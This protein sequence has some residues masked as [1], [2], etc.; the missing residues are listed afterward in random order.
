[1][2]NRNQI[3]QMANQNL[4]NE[5]EFNDLKREV[6][7]LQK[8]VNEKKA[9]YEQKMKRQQNVMARFTTASMVE[10]LK[11]AASEAE[12]ESDEISNRFLNGEMQTQE[13]VKQFLEKRKLHHLRAAK[14]EYLLVHNP[15]L[16]K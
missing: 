1:M 15:Q 14:R 12:E 8:G 3:E 2:D 4:I 13:F 11:K 16:K 7:A 6:L 9:N 10:E 5:K